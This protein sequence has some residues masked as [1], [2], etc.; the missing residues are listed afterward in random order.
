MESGHFHFAIY[1]S[2]GFLDKIWRMMYNFYNNF[3]GN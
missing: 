3:G 2:K 1:E